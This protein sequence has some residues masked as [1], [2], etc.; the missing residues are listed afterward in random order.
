[1]KT[2]NKVQLVGYLG[3]DPVLTVAK[4]G[5][6]RIQLRVATDHYYKDEK[7][8]T[9][10]V[11]TWHDVVAWD[12]IAEKVEN[13]FI[14]GSHVMVEGELQY[15]SFSDDQGNIRHVTQIKANLILNLDR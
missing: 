14:K 5:A 7:G 11:V 6:K 3:K 15:R 13:Q 10:R 8:K 12:K 4:N 1:M 2:L 9:Q